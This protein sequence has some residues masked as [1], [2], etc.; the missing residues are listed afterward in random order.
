MSRGLTFVPFRPT[1]SKYNT[2]LDCEQFF[3]TLHWMAVLCKVPRPPPLS[4]QDDIFTELFQPHQYCEPPHGKFVAVEL[5]IAKYHKEIK[6]LSSKPP[7]QL[8]LTHAEKM[9]LQSLRSWQD[10]IMKPGDKC[11]AV[12][13]FDHN[14][15][16]VEA[17]HQLD[18][19]SFYQI[20]PFPS[21]L[22][23]HSSLIKN[24]DLLL[25]AKLLIKSK[26]KQ[27]TFFYLKYTKCWSTIGTSSSENSWNLT[28]PRWTEGKMLKLLVALR[29]CMLLLCRLNRCMNVCVCIYS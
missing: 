5:D 27:P 13:V 11:G 17:H 2:L 15:Y 12:V 29:N 25:T 20:L 22:K 7:H 16:V 14:L 23:V 8:N 10:I 9:T 4:A 1:T 26:A 28:S 18:D 21:L 19:Y 24:K 3:C 6:N